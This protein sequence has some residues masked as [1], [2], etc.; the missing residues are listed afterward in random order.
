MDRVSPLINI[1]EKL[2]TFTPDPWGGSYTDPSYHIP[3][4]YDI[5][6]EW[7]N[8]ERSN[9]WKA[10]A[11]KSRK[12]LHKATHPETGLTP[13]YS[14]YDGTP[15]GSRFIIGDDFRFDS[16]RVPLNIAIDFAWNG[17]DAD[18]QRD[19]ADRIQDFFYN[20]G[21]DTFVD[22]YKTDG[23]AVERVLGAGEHHALRHSL[24]LVSTLGAASLAATDPKSREFAMRL[25]DSKHEPYED[26]YFDA[27]YDGL[28]R[29]FSFMLLSG[30]YQAIPP[31]H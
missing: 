20:E 4:F 30:N 14:S 7:A 17:S 11:D 8:D 5:W 9:F 2:I 19:Y 1:E 31:R 15:R 27:Y 6:A 25:W 10:C 26:G 12:Y 21:I 18:W 28:L 3:S 13:D 22:Q 23:S 16:W 29:L 24:G